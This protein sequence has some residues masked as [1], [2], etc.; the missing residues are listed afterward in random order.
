M[1][2][3]EHRMVAAAARYDSS[4]DGKKRLTP[5]NEPGKRPFGSAS[6]HRARAVIRRCQGDIITIVRVLLTPQ[7]AAKFENPRNLVHE[8]DG[9]NF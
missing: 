1:K 4:G 3:H 9:E 2:D 5:A 8:I 7:D 6:S